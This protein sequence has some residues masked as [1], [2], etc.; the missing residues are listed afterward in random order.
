MGALVADPNSSK[1]YAFWAGQRE[2]GPE[3]DR[4]MFMA[5]SHDEG[6]TWSDPQSLDLDIEGNCRCCPI[7]ATMDSEGGLYVI[8]RNS[9]KTSQTSWDKDTFLLKSGDGGRTWSK[10]LIE[11]WENCGCPGA[12]YSM[13]SGPTG[14]YFGFSTRGVA[15]FA[16]ASAPQKLYPAPGS[17]KPSTRPAVAV[18]ENGD[19]LFCWVEAQDVV[20]QGY[21]RDGKLIEPLS[22]RLDGVAVR[23]SNAALVATADHNFLLYHDGDAP[24]LP[25]RRKK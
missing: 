11:K 1:V 18:N 5:L 15:S 21:D 20:W 14:V 10:T 3:M 13:A 8:H 22:G 19:I 24:P 9:V 4:E 7:Q 16:K 17:G 2:P 6:R 25:A 23:W 12:P